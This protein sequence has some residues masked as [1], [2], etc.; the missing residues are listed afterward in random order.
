MWNKEAR[1]RLS[2][3]ASQCSVEIVVHGLSRHLDCASRP[4]RQPCSPVI[5]L[6]NKRKDT[7]QWARCQGK[8][9]VFQSSS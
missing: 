9:S 4:Y 7:K 6:S 3:A 5:Q 1:Q 2:C 8:C